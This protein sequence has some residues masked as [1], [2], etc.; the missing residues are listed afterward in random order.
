[1]TSNKKN[2]IN[3]TLYLDKEP[4]LG[5]DMD[6][7]PAIMMI[8]TRTANIHK[9]SGCFIMFFIFEIEKIDNSKRKVFSTPVIKLNQEP[10]SQIN[11]RYNPDITAFG[12]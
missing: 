10:V 2:G 7:R 9:Y 8:N 6:K 1:M 4:K 5:D 12:K 11:G 3:P